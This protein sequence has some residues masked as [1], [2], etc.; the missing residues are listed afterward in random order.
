MTVMRGKGREHFRI[1]PFKLSST[2]LYFQ[3]LPGGGAGNDF[4]QN[5]ISREV[6]ALE[7]P[8]D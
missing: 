2:H 4:N 1:I 8:F 5:V 3:K 7:R 6:Y